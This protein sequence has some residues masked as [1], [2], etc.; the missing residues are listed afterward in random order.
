MLGTGTSGRGR[1]R[2]RSAAKVGAARE[3]ETQCERKRRRPE[4]LDVTLG[5]KGSDI[6]VR[7]GQRRFRLNLTSQSSGDQKIK[8]KAEAN[9]D[10]DNPDA[11]VV[12]A[13]SSSFRRAFFASAVSNIASWRCSGKDHP[14]WRR[15]RGKDRSF[16]D[17]VVPFFA[18]RG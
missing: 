14:N 15:A 6:T 7:R 8:R 4:G 17:G 11:A 12:G 9:C 2:D 16:S 18:H 1:R 5:L 13:R 10:I 3:A